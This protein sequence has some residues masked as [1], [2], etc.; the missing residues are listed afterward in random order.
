MT[1][2]EE[3][4]NETKEQVDKLADKYNNTIEDDKTYNATEVKKI[5]SAYKVD[6]EKIILDRIIGLDE[7]FKTEEEILENIITSARNAKLKL[8]E[9][10]M[11]TL[12][13]IK[14]IERR[15]ISCNV[16][17]Q[18]ETSEKELVEK[19]VKEWRFL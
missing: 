7:F 16:S 10:R 2:S 19:N 15:E 11:H 5:L 3:I 9:E 12:N 1:R 18:T 14:D 17:I 6:F 13:S 4:K 8:L